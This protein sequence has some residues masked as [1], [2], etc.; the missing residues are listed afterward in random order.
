MKFYSIHHPNREWGDYSDTLFDGMASRDEQS[1][2]LMLKRTGPFVPPISFPSG[3]VVTDAFRAMLEAS[4]LTSFSFQPVIKE[5][6][7]TLDWDQWDL[8]AK[9]PEFYPDSGEPEDY[10]LEGQ[11][12]PETAEQ[13]PQ[14]WELVVKGTA[15]VERVIDKSARYGVALFLLVSTWNGDDFFR[16]PDVGYYYVTETAKA[17]LESQAPEFVA[18]KAVDTK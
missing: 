5:H 1:G 18:F 11:H 4:K 2:L 16:A 15:H 9:E 12:S 10:I 14:L 17:W 13:M 7:V 3:I 6:I 8:E